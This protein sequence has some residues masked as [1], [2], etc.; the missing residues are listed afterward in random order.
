MGT[1]TAILSNK[2][3][4]QQANIHGD[5][6]KQVYLDFSKACDTLDYDRTLTILKHYKVGSNTISLLY[7]F[8]MH[9]HITPLLAG[10]HG[11]A[12]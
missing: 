5:T 2:L 7:Y 1:G 10:C 11:K 9:H 6:L 4:L 12:F 3:L 8:W